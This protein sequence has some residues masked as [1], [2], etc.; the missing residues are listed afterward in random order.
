MP[1]LDFHTHV[2][3]RDPLTP[4]AISHFA[5]TN[6]EYTNTISHHLTRDSLVSYLDSQA[7]DKAVVLSECARTT[8]DVVT[9]KSI[10]GFCSGTDRL[11][12]FGFIRPCGGREPAIEAEHC[13][14][15]LG[16][17]GLKL[18]TPYTHFYPA[19]SRLLPAYELASAQGIPIMFRTGT[20]APVG[21]PVS[22]GGHPLLLDNLAQGFPRL[23]I[24]MCHG[25]YPVWCADA[26]RMLRRHENCYIDISGIPPSRVPRIFPHLETFRDRF[27]FGSDWPGIPSIADQVSEIEKLPFS[28]DTIDAI[29]WGNG[30]HLLGIDTHA[31]RRAG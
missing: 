5:S 22:Y 15:D 20:R 16:C 13:I 3:T 24:V 12:P 23:N 19:D 29:L 11:I 27:I 9:N 28:P 4:W 30:S 17:R 14:R 26:E 1:V 8:T 2:G 18:L 21:S 25:G 31:D 6:P 7:V 10:Q